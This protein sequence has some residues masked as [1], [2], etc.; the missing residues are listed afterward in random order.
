MRPMSTPISHRRR[1]GGRTIKKRRKSKLKIQV[2]ELADP[3]CEGLNSNQQSF[4]QS[5]SIRPDQISIG[6]NQEHQ[7]T[8]QLSCGDQVKSEQ[9]DSAKRQNSTSEK[10][11]EDDR[12]LECPVCLENPR[13]GPV[14]SCTNGHL[15]VSNFF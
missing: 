2:R 11:E 12:F 4:S 1:L 3:S 10:K 6:I 9:D 5:R 7:S 13:R 15:I 8:L 14:F